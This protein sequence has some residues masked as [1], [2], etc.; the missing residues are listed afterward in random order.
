MIF[1]NEMRMLAMFTASV[2]VAEAVYQQNR[3]LPHAEGL[4]PNEPER[5]LGGNTWSCHV[6]RNDSAPISEPPSSPSL[7]NQIDEQD[8]T[9]VVGK[10]TV[11]HFGPFRQMSSPE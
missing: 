2:G 7:F 10:K 3:R 5:K 8:V 9:Q 11:S 1:F 6:K 4:S